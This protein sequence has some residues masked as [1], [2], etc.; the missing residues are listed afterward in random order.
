MMQK[1]LEMARLR[2]VLRPSRFQEPRGA[3]LLSVRC[4]TI[5]L[6]I[7]AIVIHR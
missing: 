3:A 2:V 6:S 4:I 5:K 1:V 7:P